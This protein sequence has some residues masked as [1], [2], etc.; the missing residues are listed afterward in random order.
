MLWH[1]TVGKRGSMCGA[2]DP[3]LVVHRMCR[4]RCGVGWRC[5]VCVSVWSVWRHVLVRSTSPFGLY[6]VGGVASVYR[7][8][9]YR[10]GVLSSVCRVCLP[11]KWA[12][13][14]FGLIDTSPPPCLIKGLKE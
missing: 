10:N 2:T 12:F 8:G 13:F 9:A 11:D 3:Y 4:V 7:D 1:R 14:Y 6:C 5:A